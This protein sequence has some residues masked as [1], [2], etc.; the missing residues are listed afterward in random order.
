MSAPNSLFSHIIPRAGAAATFSLGGQASG[1]A[2]FQCWLGRSLALPRCIN[3][4]RAK[5]KI[6]FAAS[7]SETPETRSPRSGRTVSEDTPW[8][9]RIGPDRSTRH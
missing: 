1:R 9:R 6:D 2:S 7:H 5:Y 3:P 4:A 8:P